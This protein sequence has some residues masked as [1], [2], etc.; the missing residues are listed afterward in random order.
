[1]PQWT[2]KRELLG[3]AEIRPVGPFTAG[4]YSGFELI[5]TAGFFG[6]DDSGSLKIVQRFASDMSSPQFDDTG[7]PGY[8]TAEASNGAELRLRY[9][10][11]DNIRPWGKT[12]YIKIL[13]GYLR[14]GDRIVV[15]FG[16]RRSGSPGIRMQTFCEHT[17]E[18]KVL[19]DAFATYEYVELPRNPVF[20]VGSG[21]AVRWR[22]PLPTLRRSG[23]PGDQLVRRRWNAALPEQSASDRFGEERRWGRDPPSPTLLGGHAR[24]ERGD[25]PRGGADGRDGGH[26]PHLGSSRRV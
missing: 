18:L 16:D 23:E 7:A 11:K 6:I 20:E 10:V 22:A 19:V 25:H 2:Y 13:R 8:L 14:E 4:E 26:P 12:L 3:H 15:R 1:V 21:M 9:D 5:Y 24:A 17:F